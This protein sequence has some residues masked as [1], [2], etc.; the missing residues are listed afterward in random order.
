M[1]VKAALTYEV[2]EAAHALGKSVATIRNWIK[3]GLPVMTSRKPYLILGADIRSYIKAKSKAAKSPLAKNE[4]YCLSCRAGRKP[5]DMAVEAFPN[6]PKTTRLM[7]ICGRCGA[8]TT[9]MISNAKTDEFA[10]TFQ[11]K[12]SGRS[13]A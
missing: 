10:Q 13:H 3:D 1:A 4:L 7:G 5:L 9:R 11:I 2:G 12:A 6:T 8:R